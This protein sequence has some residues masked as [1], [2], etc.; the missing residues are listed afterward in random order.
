MKHFIKQ[1]NK[2]FQFTHFSVSVMCNPW[3]KKSSVP[4]LLG[5]KSGGLKSVAADHWPNSTSSDNT[6]QDH[7]EKGELELSDLESAATL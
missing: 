7:A 4:L 5:V 1:A 2:N 3:G 6:S